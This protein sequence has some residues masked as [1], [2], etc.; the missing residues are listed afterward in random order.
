MKRFVLF[1][2]SLL[3]AFS[4]FATPAQA[5]PAD[6]PVLVAYF[7][8]SGNTRAFASIIA[9]E[10]GGDIF[11]IAPAV[12]Y[13]SSYEA[14]TRRWREERDQNARPALAR[15]AP[16]LDR[17]DVIFVGFPIWGGDIPHV[18][19]TFLDGANL[20]GKTIVPFCTHGGGGWERSLT[21]LARLC[22]GATIAPSLAMRGR[23]AADNRGE[24][25]RWVD[26]IRN[27]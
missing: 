23:S 11:E 15:Q 10:T 2:V 20:S 13:P 22:P 16:A 18:V 8:H 25:T 5:A 19:R 4:A 12:P 9:E 6:S 26:A 27:S 17:Y 7:S 21:T 1:L 24:I 3:L 14:T